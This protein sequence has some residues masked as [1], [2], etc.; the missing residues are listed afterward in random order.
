MNNKLNDGSNKLKNIRNCAELL[1]PDELKGE[2]IAAAVKERPD[3]ILMPGMMPQ[4]INSLSLAASNAMKTPAIFVLTQK[5]WKPGRVLK[6]RFLDNPPQIVKQKIE[7][8]ARQ[9]ES[10]VNIK[11]S[12]GNAIDAEIRITCTLGIGSWSYLGTD[13]LVIPPNKPTMNYGWFTETTPDTEYSRTVLHE[14]GHALG[15]GHEHQHP[16]AGIPWNRPVVYQYYQ[17]TQGW[18]KADVD[19]QIF[20]KYNLNQLN[21]SVY[22]KNS[23][24]H[25]AIDK[26]LLLDP[27]FAVGWNTRLSLMDKSFMKLMY[28]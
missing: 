23:I 10:V 27:S 22:D 6:V 19:A 18:S 11:F 16:L 25:Y 12:F 9:W 8:F 1:V 7:Q 14:F 21:A 5:R 3:N 13:A 17:S 4:G 15:A 26:Q 24:M 2:A 20:A 28:P